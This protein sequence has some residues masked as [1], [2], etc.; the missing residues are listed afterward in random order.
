MAKTRF[1]CLVAA[2]CMVGTACGGGSAPAEEEASTTE[3]GE[4]TVVAEP[5]PPPPPPIRPVPTMQIA[6]TR[7]TKRVFA[8]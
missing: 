3:G 7:H 4:T 6:A 2:I 8:I 1:V 5:T